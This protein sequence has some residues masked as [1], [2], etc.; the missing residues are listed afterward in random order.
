MWHIY[1]ASLLAALLLP[2][3]LSAG[4]ITGKPLAQA[5]HN[6]PCMKCHKRNGSMQGIHG[7]SDI[8]CIDCHGEKQ[9]HPRKAS[10]LVK[11][12]DPASTLQAQI[13]PCL[14]CH[15]PRSL[16]ESEW[17]HDVHILGVSCSSC[18]QLHLAQDPMRTLTPTDRVALC[19]ECHRSQ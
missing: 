5:I 8:R 12:N 18:H 7:Q 15:D 16:G 4:D 19:S 17:T 9:G 6:S 13:T 2:L 1:A 11:F 10:N 14:N 3:P